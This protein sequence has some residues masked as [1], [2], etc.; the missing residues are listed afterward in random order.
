MDDMKPSETDIIP[1][2]SEIEREILS[3]EKKLAEKESEGYLGTPYELFF[4]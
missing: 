1:T 4:T 2:T 3:W